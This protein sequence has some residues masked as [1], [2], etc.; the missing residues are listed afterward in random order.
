MPR[1]EYKHP[2][3]EHYL[4]LW[5]KARKIA[6]KARLKHY[7]CPSCNSID[8]VFF[9]PIGR[10]ETEATRHVYLEVGCSNCSIDPVRLDIEKGRLDPLDYFHK[11]VDHFNSIQKGQKEIMERR[12]NQKQLEKCNERGQC[13]CLDCAYAQ[14]DKPKPAMPSLCKCPCDSPPTSAVLEC[15]EYRKMA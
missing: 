12:R 7:V 10:Y 9:R 3:Q 8:R 15:S 4:R 14:R 13:K 1:D 11:F 5:K 6:D 2:A